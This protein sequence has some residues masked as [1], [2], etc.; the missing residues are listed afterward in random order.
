[1]KNR[2]DISIKGVSDYSEDELLKMFSDIRITEKIDGVKINVIVGD[3][4]N[5]VSYK[6]DI[7]YTE[8]FLHCKTD[9]EKGLGYSQ[10]MFALEELRFRHFDFPLGTE[11]FFEFSMR[12][13]TLSR[14]YLKLHKLFMIGYS[15]P[16]QVRM[17]PGKVFTTPGE[18]NVYSIDKFEFPFILR[19]NFSKE[20]VLNLHQYLDFSTQHV[21]GSW[22]SDTVSET[23]ERLKAALLKRDSALGGEP[24]GAV[25]I[26]PLGFQKITQPN[27]YDKTHR[28]NFRLKWEMEKAQETEYYASVKECA[29]QIV[30]NLP[31]NEKLEE[32]LG[33]LAMKAYKSNTVKIS[34]P[35]K[36]DFQVREDLYWNCRQLLLRTLK[37]NNG[38]LFIGRIQPFTKM[39]ASIMRD[40]LEKF[41]YVVVAIVRGKKSEKAENPFPFELQKRMINSV[42]PDVKIIEVSTGAIVPAIL[43]AECN[44]NAVFCGSDRSA[45]Y[46]EQ[47]KNMPE[48]QLC[49]IERI[50]HVSATEARKALRE[51]D[52]QKF[53]QQVEEPVGELFSNLRE[54]I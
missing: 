12:K 3:R 50:Q 4:E 41:D 46:A 18:L 24:E 45:G 32:M 19:G 31:R 27:Q 8:E 30:E 54:Y 21:Y 13:P 20:Q 34:H 17:Y 44:I 15:K 7:L 1:M 49:S 28:A 35:L 11:L 23:W 26:S 9:A 10:F 25:I 40:A 14:E 47:L 6:G 29:R 51:N 22:P 5:T 43:R 16:I 39:H 37:G 52:K 38:A 42:F 48:I 53:L 36:T 2:L 33:E